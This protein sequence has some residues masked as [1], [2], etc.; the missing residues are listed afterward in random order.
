MHFLSAGM[1]DAVETQLMRWIAI[2]TRW[3]A[4]L[5]FDQDQLEILFREVGNAEDSP[6][7]T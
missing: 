6:G 1:H 7:W 2:E 4:L 3:S 5:N